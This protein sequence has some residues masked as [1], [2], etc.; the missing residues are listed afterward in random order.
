MEICLQ[1][2]VTPKFALKRK[3]GA[4]FRC[5]DANY[6]KKNW[7]Q[8]VGHPESGRLGTRC[9]DK[10]W[11]FDPL[12]FLSQISPSLVPLS[13]VLLPPR[14]PSIFHLFPSTFLTKF[15]ISLHYHHLLLQTSLS[16]SLSPTFWS[17]RKWRLEETHYSLLTPIFSSIF[18]GKFLT[19]PSSFT[20]D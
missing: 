1:V 5:L 18:W 9:E 13:R 19:L 14:I 11:N 17:E 7:L 12:S 8:V 15:I 2:W 20:M 4:S 6:A 16:L 3:K 10:I